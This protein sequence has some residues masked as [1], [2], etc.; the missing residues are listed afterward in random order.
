MAYLPLLCIV[1]GLSWADFWPVYRAPESGSRAMLVKAAVAS[2]LFLSALALL[3]VGTD[4]LTAVLLV[5]ISLAIAGM[6]HR[7][8]SS[9]LSLSLASA[10]FACYFIG[11]PL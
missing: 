9:P 5:A 6:A 3:S 8:L 7:R 2:S 11:T 1:I 10:S 4:A